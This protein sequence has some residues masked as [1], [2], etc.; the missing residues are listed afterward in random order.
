MN[1]PNLKRRKTYVAQTKIFKVVLV[2]MLI[3]EH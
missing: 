2:R 3:I 1:G